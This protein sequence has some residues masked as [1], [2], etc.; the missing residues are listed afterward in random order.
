[1]FFYLPRIVGDQ[2]LDGTLH[3][4]LGLCYTITQM[5][6]AETHFSPPPPRLILR[7]LT[8]SGSSAYV[9]NN[10]FIIICSSFT[11][12]AKVIFLSTVDR[13][14]RGCTRF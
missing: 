3:L 1:M 14:A 5:L 11:F 13:V 4:G 12:D 8:P 10:C 6:G 2:L 7:G 9:Y